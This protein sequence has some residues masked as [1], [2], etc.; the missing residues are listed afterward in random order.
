MPSLVRIT[1]WWS[2]LTELHKLIGKVIRVLFLITTFTRLF[3]WKLQKLQ[4]SHW[5]QSWSN[6]TGSVRLMQCKNESR[7]ILVE[8]LV[9]HSQVQVVAVQLQQSDDKKWDTCVEML[10]CTLC[11]KAYG[12]FCL[13][14]YCL[15]S[16]S[17]IL[18]NEG[19]SAVLW[20]L[21]ITFGMIH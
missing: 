7:L 17:L 10:A 8:Y 2:T 1:L 13:H 5:V 21:T 4:D 11:S 19:L 16:I 20:G 18:P 14:H 12:D 6:K 15:C 3:S 9:C